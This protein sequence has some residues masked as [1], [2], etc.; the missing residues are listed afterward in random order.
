[1]ARCDAGGPRSSCRFHPGRTAVR[2]TVLGVLLS[3]WRELAAPRVVLCPGTFT[4]AV[5]YLGSRTHRAGRWGEGS[6]DALGAD[7][8]QRGLALQRLK[9]GTS[10]RIRARQCGLYGHAAAALRVARRRV[11]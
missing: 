9:T 10:P 3:D 5:C 4:R 1:M 2:P 6:A 7:L 8:A 11:L